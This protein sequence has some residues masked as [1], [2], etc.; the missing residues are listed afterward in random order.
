MGQ[1]DGQLIRGF[2]PTVTANITLL[3]S[4]H[5]PTKLRT[6]IGT[7]ILTT[8]ANSSLRY[9]PVASE[10]ALSSSSH[11]S[12]SLIDHPRRASVPAGAQSVFGEVVALHARD[13]SLVTAVGEQRAGRVQSDVVAPEQQ[14]IATCTR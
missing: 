11:P 14:V 3:P 2:L 5:D 1:L 9:H 6:D 7:S 4:T 8:K 12:V 13:A 10:S